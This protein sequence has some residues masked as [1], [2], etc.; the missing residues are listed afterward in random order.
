MIDYREIET[1]LFDR[2]I[3]ITFDDFLF[4]LLVTNGMEKYHAYAQT[5]K[6][7]EYE[8]V[9]KLPKESA[10]FNKIKKD[11]D[12]YM[13][14]QNITQLMDDMES[15]Y[16]QNVQ[17]EALQLDDIDLSARDIK[18]IINK[19]LKSRVEDLDGSSTK[20]IVELLKMLLNN[21]VSDD[22]LGKDFQRHFIQVFPP[23]NAVCSVCGHEFDVPRN[24]D[25]ICPYCHTKYVYNKA[26]DKYFPELNSL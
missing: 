22:S 25:A 5:I 19:L 24:I 6:R 16:K 13:Q 7:K 23:Y 21:F 3:T 8:K 18:N 26:E 10:F 12:I 1:R 9:A 20:E 4:C 17:A 14:T 2:G 15:I 11:C